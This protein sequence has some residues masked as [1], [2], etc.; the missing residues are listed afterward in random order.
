MSQGLQKCE[1]AVRKEFKK[2]TRGF[3]EDEQKNPRIAMI[4]KL[5]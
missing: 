4:Y 2:L 3:G 5:Q 1:E